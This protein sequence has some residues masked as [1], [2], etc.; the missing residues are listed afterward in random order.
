MNKY[1]L[2]LG[3]FDGLHKGH[4][5]VLETTKEFA[6]QGLIPAMLMF[7]CHPL[8]AVKGI[9]PP[10]LITQVNKHDK[11]RQDNLREVD[12]TLIHRRLKN[13]VPELL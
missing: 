2:A 13:D 5:Q 10:L 9:N 1:A 11:F 3:T 4:L 7:D 12:H 6:S 8:K